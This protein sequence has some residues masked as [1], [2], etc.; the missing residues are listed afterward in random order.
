M[1][2]T[3]RSNQKLLRNKRNSD[4]RLLA[5]V[6]SV[7]G[8][9][10]VHAQVSPVPT[11]SF[12]RIGS[13][14]NGEYFYS[15]EPAEA[16][17]IQAFFGPNFNSVAATALRTSDS[18]APTLM[19]VNMMETTAGVPDVPSSYFLLDTN[20]NKICN[21][22]GSPPNYILNL[23]NPTVAT[24][25]GQYAAQVYLQ[26]NPK[27]NGLFFDNLIEQIANLSSDCYGN[28]IQISS[29]G[30]GIADQPAALNAAWIQ[31]LY[32]V[33]TTF[34]SLAPNAYVVVHANEL[35][36][37][38][39]VL[40]LAN[41]DVF[42]F[43]I[44]N[45]REGSL[46]F[47]TLWNAY[48]EWFSAGQAPVLASIHSSPPNQI[49]YGYGYTPVVNAL[50]QTITFGETFYPNMRF[51]LATALMNNGFSIFDFG[52]NSSQVAAWFDEYNFKLGQPVTPAQLVGSYTAVNELTNSEFTSGLTGWSFQVTNDGS[53][54]A[55]LVLDNT[56]TLGSKESAHLDVVSAATAAWHIDLEQDRVPISAGQEYQ[57]QFWAKS[58]TTFPIQIAIQGGAPA[59][60]Y[61]A[62]ASSVTVSGAWNQYSIS[63]VATTT[64]ND[65]R[66]EF[67]L[68]GGVG[69]VWLD[70]I[71]LLKAPVQIYRR[72]FQA[73]VVLLNATSAS[74]TVSLE[75][76]LKRFSGM[77]APK[78]Q[79]IVD[80]SSSAFSS[81]GSWTVSKIDT[82][83]RKAAGPYYHAWQGT[84]H[85][86]TGAGSAKW[87]L[88]IPAN[89]QYTLQVWLP[90]SP[91]ASTWTKDAIYRVTQNGSVI[92]TVSLDQSQAAKGD[93][94]FNLGTFTL[95]ANE[96]P[97]LTISNGSSGFLIAD[98]VYVFSAMD[99]YNDGAAVSSVTIPPMDGILLSRETPNQVIIFPAP[100][101]KSVGADVALAATAS[102]GLPVSY[103]S[104][105]PTV[106]QVA[107]NVA[108]MLSAGTCSI[109]ASEAGNGGITAA[110]PVTQSFLVN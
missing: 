74:Q 68:G 88:E 24:Y 83:W 102:S 20:G 97:S 50:P 90:A 43:D 35:P 82:G 2:G 44:P 54:E 9:I 84:L 104:N 67:R 45:I 71:Q 107:G 3:V 55:T 87:N 92:A 34:K 59:F 16:S 106:C 58:D 96:S 13:V 19:S 57:L 98:A 53:A 103:Y 32:T 73:G 1:F 100:G 29:Q 40:A 52:D 108:A 80:D 36:A 76:G 95:T 42:T 46:A 77:Q 61:Y 75:S 51:G 6:A 109:T 15:N 85:Q 14:W 41:G 101:K 70:G 99:R 18:D 33:L 79:Y 105:S 7:L 63:F 17:Q 78:Y 47:G 94:W 38:P 48:Q 110:V 25:V 4:L 60:A 30:N 37:D 28:A 89:G 69:N 91:A 65:G 11:G 72:D 21:W 39:N 62:P 31:G 81:T 8:G 22:P 23:T 26:S 64:A 27:Y 86:S 49:A 12:P 10:I 5:T 66:L 56:T 93:Q